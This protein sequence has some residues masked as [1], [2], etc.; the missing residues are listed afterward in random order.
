MVKI[1][2]KLRDELK[3]LA[4]KMH[5]SDYILPQFRY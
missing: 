5:G 3:G 4:D 2:N 1:K